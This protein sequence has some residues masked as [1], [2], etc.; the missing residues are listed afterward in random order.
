VVLGAAG[1]CQNSELFFWLLTPH[2]PLASSSQA[3]DWLR[4]CDNATNGTKGPATLKSLR[5]VGAQEGGG[6]ASSAQPAVRANT[7]ARAVAPA[8]VGQ[9]PCTTLR[10][11][12]GAWPMPGLHAASRPFPRPARSCCTLASAWAWRWSRSSRCACASG[13]G[14]GRTA[15]S[16]PRAPRPRC[17]TFSRWAG[18]GARARHCRVQPCRP[19]P[20]LPLAPGSTPTPA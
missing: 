1:A 17:P 13:G 11:S 10:A 14:S 2:R 5:E 18:A 16:A 4:R 6:G 8:I 20:L 9:R 19:Q 3:N 7:A 12:S 15:P